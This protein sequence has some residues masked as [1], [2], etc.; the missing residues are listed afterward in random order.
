MDRAG[1][2]W[3]AGADEDA[4]VGFGGTTAETADETG[5]MTREIVHRTETS[6]AASARG[7]GGTVTV[8]DVILFEV[9]DRPHHRM[10]GADHL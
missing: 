4:G 8:M 7:T 5:N 1:D 10:G 6:G 2:I 9:D 3:V